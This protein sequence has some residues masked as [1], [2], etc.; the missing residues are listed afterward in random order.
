MA[1]YAAVS[2]VVGRYRWRPRHRA[3]HVPAAS[4]S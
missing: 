3:A 2:T 1:L 4:R